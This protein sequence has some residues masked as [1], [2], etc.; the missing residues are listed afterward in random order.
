MAAAKSDS[1]LPAW[2]RRRSQRSCRGDSRRCWGPGSDCG[3]AAARY[4]ISSAQPS[5][6]PCRA[7]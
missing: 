3:A 2:C 1:G 4:T 7:R 6:P 5:R